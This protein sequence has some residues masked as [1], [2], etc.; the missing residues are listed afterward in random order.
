[1]TY[2]QV[3]A[4]MLDPEPPNVGVARRFLRQHLDGS[5]LDDK[6]VDT[7]ELLTSELVTNA[8]LHASSPV[9]VRVG[10]GSGARVAVRDDNGQDP[11]RR[12]HSENSVAGRGLEL[13]ELLATGYGVD[14]DGGEGKTVWFTVGQREQSSLGIDPRC[15]G[16]WVSEQSSPAPST[17]RVELLGM[18][19]ARYDDMREQNEALLRECTL[20]RLTERPG[21][22]PRASEISAADRARISVVRAFLEQ[23]AQFPVDQTPEFMD[24]L[25]DVEDADVQGF[26]NMVEI[27]AHVDKLSERSRLLALPASP[28]V[29]ALRDWTF[30][31]VINQMHGNKPTRWTESRV[32]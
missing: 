18:P 12:D 22:G 24:V 21:A 2:E 8:I 19:V 11:V 4:V 9:E 17:T 26:E 15:E 25:V 13:V 14:R 30:G 16:S 20:T 32:S 27:F 6:V 7:A 10:L 31:E 29:R 23:R 5:G 28:Q 1:M 3:G